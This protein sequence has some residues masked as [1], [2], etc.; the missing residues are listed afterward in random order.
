MAT[1]S[2]PRGSATTTVTAG[3]DMPQ[4][5]TPI[6]DGQRAAF[7]Q[8]ATEFN[9][10][11]VILFGSRARGD[12]RPDSDWDVAIV[13]GPP[14]GEQR[15]GIQERLGKIVGSASVEL[16][17]VKVDALD[18]GIHADSIWLAIAEDAVHLAGDAS[19]L[20]QAR[21]APRLRDPIERPRNICGWPW[22]EAGIFACEHE[23]TATAVEEWA[24]NG[25]ELDADEHRRLGSY[26]SCAFVEPLTRSV[27]CTFGVNSG[28]PWSVPIAWHRVGE[29]WRRQQGGVLKPS[30]QVV[31]DRVPALDGP[32][33]KTFGPDDPRRSESPARWMLRT[34]AGI[35][36][37]LAWFAALAGLASTASPFHGVWGRETVERHREPL[38][39]AIEF[40]LSRARTDMIG[41]WMD[42]TIKRR[43]HVA[44]RR[45]ERGLDR[46]RWNL[47]VRGEW[48]DE[49]VWEERWR[50][51][52]RA[53][54]TSSE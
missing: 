4:D 34:R 37:A 6:R 30:Q 51:R 38:A 18:P 25:Q 31:L 42:N 41:G 49:R 46:I 28:G 52:R 36:I 5:L 13:D 8:L 9:L 3:P 12:H 22:L 19:I 45:L 43:S 24:A 23:L 26:Y 40:A 33:R 53:R 21:E 17:S 10:S 16:V 1:K 50:W 48:E 54:M 11:A 7:E 47:I 29:Q 44:Y 20:R 35:E 15:D 2:V 27:A 14:H 32:R 39:S